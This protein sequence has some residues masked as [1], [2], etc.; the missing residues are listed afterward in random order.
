MRT[1]MIAASRMQ[2]G[3]LEMKMRFSSFV[4]PSRAQSSVTEQATPRVLR[5][6]C[7]R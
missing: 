4:T 2:E 1:E 5:N 3:T 6:E 7:L